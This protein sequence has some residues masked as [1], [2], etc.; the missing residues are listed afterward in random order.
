MLNN[1]S[2]IA[3]NKF[4]LIY[5]FNKSSPLFARVAHDLIENNKIDSALDIL[6]KGIKIF[7][8]YPTAYFVYAK[9]LAM[10]GNLESANNMVAAGSEILG[11]EST[12][13]F[14]SNLISELAG[15]S[16]ELTESKRV[17]FFNDETEE[18]NASNSD[19]FE[20]NLSELADKLDGAKI[21][22]PPEEDLPP[23]TENSPD[24]ENTNDRKEFDIS[25]LNKDLISP[26]LAEIFVAQGNLSAAKAIYIKLIELEPEKAEVFN[27]KISKIDSKINEQ[28]LTDEA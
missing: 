24:D 10:S 26:T 13:E 18:M 16:H 12:K 8:S 4:A 11:N 21:E 9:A 23:E 20:E 19:V 6:E 5:E 25:T 7:P 3:A 14:Y 28:N 1:I 2:N 22:L 15:K 27:D 17:N